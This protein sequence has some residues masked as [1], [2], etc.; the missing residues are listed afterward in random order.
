[1]AKILLT[2]ATGFL[3]SHLLESFVSKGHEVTVL[4][5]S[6]SDTWRIDHLLHKIISFNTDQVNLKTIFQEIKH[7]IVVHTACSYGRKNESL[8][9]IVNSNLIFGLDLLEESINSNVNTFINTDSLLPRNLND[10]SLS[11]AQFTDWLQKCSDKI[12]VVNFK[13]EHMYGLKDDTKKFLPWLINEM[14]NGI[15]DISLTSGIQK[16]DFIYIS[17]VVTAYD[18]V[19][20]KRQS[21]PSWNVFDIGTNVFTE[22]KDFVLKIANKLE[23]SYN[24]Q[25]VSRLKFGAIPYRSGDIMLP[26]L[27]NRKLIELGWNPKVAVIDGIQKILKK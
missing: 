1:M 26:H 18:L 21:L 19:I 12:Q 24:T 10:Y 6:T 22:V 2:G 14:I 13:I 15:D 16:R 8:L 23:I 27:D 20:Q 11:K 9:D 7:D 3:G 17:D 4:K 5:R 25:I